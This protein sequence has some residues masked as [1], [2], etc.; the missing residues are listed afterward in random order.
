M[1]PLTTLEEELA[2][3]ERVLRTEQEWFLTTQVEP[4]LRT[5]QL[6]L[7]ELT[8][9]L[10]KLAVV[11]TAIHS[12]VPI[13]AT[14]PSSG[15]TGLSI[16]ALSNASSTAV[17]SAASSI[18]MDIGATTA[19]T[20]NTSSEAT[21]ATTTASDPATSTLTV[22]S[23]PRREEGEEKEE[24]EGDEEGDE[25]SMTGPQSVT[26]PMQG[27]NLILQQTL[28]SLPH[29]SATVTATTGG[30]TS[31]TGTGTTTPTSSAPPSGTAAVVITATSGSLLAPAVVVPLPPSNTNQ[32]LHSHRTPGHVTQPYLL[33]QIKDV[34]N[35]IMEA[36]HR[37]E[38]YWAMIIAS[39]NNNGF[40]SN[41]HHLER[42]EQANAT[43]SSSSSPSSLSSKTPLTLDIQETTR[44][45]KTLLGL[46]ERHIRAAIDAMAR[47][48]KEKLYPFRVCDP[49]IF[50][51]ALSEDFVIEFF[52]RDSQVVCA[53]YALQLTGGNTSGSYSGGN[54]R[55]NYLQQTPT[56]APT[57]S[58]SGSSPSLEGHHLRHQH[59]H[60]PSNTSHQQHQQQQQQQK[61][62]TQ[63]GRDGGDRGNQK[64]QAT[65]RPP[66][67]VSHHHT[68]SSQPNHHH[69]QQ[70]LA[71]KALPW[72]PSRSPS[73]SQQPRYAGSEYQP[74]SS[75][76]TSLIPPTNG[77]K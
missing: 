56:G 39:N 5:I 30:T 24:G 38:D 20:E 53:A 1:A 31:G 4:N 43:S 17:S 44:T 27:P 60:G 8:I 33:E 18:K 71:S 32:L 11:K 45:L 19:N 52:I 77:M 58:S 70:Q 66:S 61:G 48:R 68:I 65:L 73:S 6:A 34:Q 51:P 42:Q 15:A 69:Q 35:H 67:P 28:G 41:S 22:A 14:A 3:E 16:P 62:A 76:T 2:E 47:P 13:N 59:L 10:P 7:V 29:S 64:G 21:T 23:A 57:Q 12:Y 54:T 37:L 63:A 9:K 75:A 46:V 40:G 72:S 55:T 50:S 26:V 36:M 74:N 25:G 49:K